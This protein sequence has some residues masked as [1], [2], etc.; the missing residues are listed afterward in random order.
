MGL[1]IG[2]NLPNMYLGEDAPTIYLGDEKVYPLGPFEGI[3]VPKSK[4]FECDGGNSNLYVQSSE[5]WTLSCDA[6]WLSFSQTAGTEGKST[7]V[8]TATALGED[9]EEDRTAQ[10]QF[11]TANYSATC[12]VTQFALVTIVCANN[13]GNTTNYGYQQNNVY[14]FDDT[15]EVV[16]VR[17]YD[18]TGIKSIMGRVEFSAFAGGQ[19]PGVFIG[20]FNNNHRYIKYF[21]ANIDDVVAIP[22]IFGEQ[23][24]TKIDTVILHNTSNLKNIRK[25][26]LNCTNLKKVSIDTLKNATS[27]PEN[28]Q[29]KGCTS[30]TDFYTSEL[31]NININWGFDTCPLS[32]ESLLNIINALPTVS[33]TKTIKLGTSNLNKL[34]DEEKALATAKMWSLTA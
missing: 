31:P 5:S 7:V 26:F 6:D 33:S 30:L 24:D 27:S 18:F 8:V 12:N 19:M 1:Y 10:I 3:K 15:V 25:A 14:S 11:T 28:E 23:N 9:A 34:T 13:L 2:T 29:F 22:Y 20:S 17:H 4:T 32:H 21:E 16:K